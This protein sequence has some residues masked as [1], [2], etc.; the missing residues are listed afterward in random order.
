MEGGIFGYLLKLYLEYIFKLSINKSL[1]FSVGISYFK[2]SKLVPSDIEKKTLFALILHAYC[3]YRRNTLHLPCHVT[4]VN[5]S[6]VDCLSIHS[7][8]KTPPT[9]LD[10]ESNQR[11]ISSCGEMSCCSLM[12]NAEVQREQ[13][14]ET[15]CDPVLL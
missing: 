5:G 7:K 6:L 14:Q 4:L 3:I 13:Q 8:F 12:K 2:T 15:S 1:N 11:T 10:T 9:A